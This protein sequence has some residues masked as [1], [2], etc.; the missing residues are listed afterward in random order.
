MLQELTTPHGEVP[1]KTPWNVYPRPQMRRDSYWNLNGQWQ[2]AVQKPEFD[3]KTILV[4]F[5]PESVLSGVKEHFPEGTPLWYRRS[6]V[7]PEGFNRGRVLLAS[8]HR[9]KQN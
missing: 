1:M 7:L 3:D 5:C 6:F 2:F 4:P 8:R 9:T